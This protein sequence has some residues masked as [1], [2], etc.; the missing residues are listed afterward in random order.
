MNYGRRL[1]NLF[2]REFSLFDMN[3]RHINSFHYFAR[4]YI[5]SKSENAKGCDK[6]EGKL[7]GVIWH[8]MKYPKM[9]AFSGPYFII[10]FRKQFYKRL[11]ANAKV[12]IRYI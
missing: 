11:D 7:F 8:C 6:I 3:D 2:P 1:N 9:R 10:H 12:I 5:I 4:L